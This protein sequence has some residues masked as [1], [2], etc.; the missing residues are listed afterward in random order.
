M[1]TTPTYDNF[2]DERDA[3]KHF[4]A[5]GDPEAFAFITARYQSMVFGTCH[6]ILKSRQRRILPMDLSAAQKLVLSTP[7]L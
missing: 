5:T 7:R 1:T 4:A 3:L 6:R 2:A